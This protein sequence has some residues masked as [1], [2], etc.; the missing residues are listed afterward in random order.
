MNVADICD[1]LIEP[2]QS[3]RKKEPTILDEFFG[4]YCLISRSPKACYKN[5]CYVGYTVDPNRRV[6]QHNAGKEFGGAK[7]TDSRGPWDM[8]CIVHGF[9]NSVSALR[10]EWAWQNPKGSKRLRDLGLEK[11]GRKESPFDFH[12][13]IVCNMLNVDPWKRL[14]LTFRWLVISEERE[15]KIKMP[16][17]MK[18]EHGLVQKTHSTIP[19]QLKDYDKPGGCLICHFTIHLNDLM[20]CTLG[21]CG[22]SYHIKCLAEYGIRSTNESENFLFPIIVKCKKCEAPQ[23]WGDLVRKHKCYIAIDKAKPVIDD[24][25]IAEG[26]IPKYM[27][28]V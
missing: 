10:F 4:V 13:R 11:A 12:F 22:A 23:R 21:A 27:H 24:Y 3:R 8:V 17:H 7:K 5:R 9:P 15:F 25:K 16:S 28:K 1:L 18:V 2:S 20:V 26:L 19:Q 14:S 6:R